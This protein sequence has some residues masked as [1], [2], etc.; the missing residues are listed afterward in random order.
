[1]KIEIV[2]VYHINTTSA[3][4]MSEQGTG[5]SLYPATSSMYYDEGDDGGR[6]YTLPAGYEVARS[7]T[8]ERAIYNRD[9]RHCN[10]WHDADGRPAILTYEGNIITLHPA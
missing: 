5:Y 9:E 2:K 1:M 4:M 6:N 3:Y 10:L 8:G 7:M